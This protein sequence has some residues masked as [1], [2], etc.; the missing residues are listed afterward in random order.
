M[1]DTT[2]SKIAV[3]RGNPEQT[4]TTPQTLCWPGL[5]MWLQGTLWSC[6]NWKSGSKT[7]SHISWRIS[8]RHTLDIRHFCRK[9]NFSSVHVLIN[10]EADSTCSLEYPPGVVHVDYDSGSVFSSFSSLHISLYSLYDNSHSYQQCKPIVIYFCIKNQK[11]KYYLDVWLIY[12]S[13]D[14][15]TTGQSWGLERVCMESVP[16][17]TFTLVLRI[18]PGNQA[19]I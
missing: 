13:G 18:K 15:C 12:M 11:H 1:S 4:G 16:S 5:E 9:N 3:F 2:G 7:K 8:H 17:P 14:M 10:S 6:R 19:R